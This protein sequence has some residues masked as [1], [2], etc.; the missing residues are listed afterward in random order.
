MKLQIKFSSPATQISTILCLHMA[1]ILIRATQLYPE[2]IQY[3]TNILL[4]CL[5]NLD[6]LEKPLLYCKTGLYRGIHYFSLFF[7][8][9]IDCQHLLEPP[10]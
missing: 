2:T 5:G 10:K 6:T 9:N 4:T 1:E 3:G 8:Q 7:A